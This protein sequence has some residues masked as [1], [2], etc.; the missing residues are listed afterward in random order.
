MPST[1]DV[2]LVLTHGAM[3]AP[4]SSRELR[5]AGQ[6][7]HPPA[8]LSL[9]SLMV[10]WRRRGQ[11]GASLLVGFCEHVIEK[12]L[13]SMYKQIGSSS[14]WW[15]ASAS[16]SSRIQ[17]AGLDVRAS[18]VLSSSSGGWWAS[19]HITENVGSVGP[20]V[21]VYE[22]AGCYVIKLVVSFCERIIENSS[23][24]WWASASASSRIS[25]YKYSLQ[26]Q[27]RK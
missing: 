14:S 20:E 27:V 13:V 7:C 22:Q 2:S 6:C 16:T 8:M 24:W 5:S 3:A 17:C 25:V 15:W 23:S 26:V 4:G 19:V 21:S 1:D 11:Q 18:G 10:P 12:F 9:G